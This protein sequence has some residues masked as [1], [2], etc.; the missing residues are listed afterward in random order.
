MQKKKNVSKLI[1]TL[2]AL[3]L[4]IFTTSGV[5]FLQARN[6]KIESENI[7]CSGTDH[8]ALVNGII[9]EV[10]NPRCWG[11]IDRKIR[12]SEQLKKI[13]LATAVVGVML[14]IATGVRVQ[15]EIIKRNAKKE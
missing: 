9:Q 4:L 6:I 8:P 10:N 13:A 5:T 3:C 2:I 15:M 1:I 12:S 14:G 11:Q 7:Q